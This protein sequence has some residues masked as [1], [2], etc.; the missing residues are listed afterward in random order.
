MDYCDSLEVTASGTVGKQVFAAG[1]SPKQVKLCGFVLTASGTSAGMV[2]I[3]DGNASGE[4]KY[5][6]R[7]VLNT[8]R[9]VEV[10]CQRFDKGMHVKVLGGATCYLQLA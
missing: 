5:T 3:R 1:A 7:T 9:P 4:V 8:S 10:G 2:V 6:V